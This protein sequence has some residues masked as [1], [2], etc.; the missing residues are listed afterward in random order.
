MDYIQIDRT[1]CM[2]IILLEFPAF[3]TQWALHLESWNPQIDRPIALDIAEFAD[4]AIDTICL[5]LDADIEHLAAITQ[6]MLLKGDAVINYAFRTMF[7][8]QIAHRS[9]RSGFSVEAFITKLQ[10]LGYYHWLEIDSRCSIYPAGVG[11]GE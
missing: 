1:N 5:G 2:E 9:S 4:F 6:L 3:E 11:S 10:P 7:L 8:E